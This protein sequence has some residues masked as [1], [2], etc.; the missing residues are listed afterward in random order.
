DGQT[1]TGSWQQPC[2][3]SWTWTWTWD[4]SAGISS[5]GPTDTTAAETAAQ[6]GGAATEIGAITQSNSAASVAD[7]SVERS[8]AQ[9]FDQSQIA[10][11]ATGAENQSITAEQTL[12]SSQD[13]LASAEADQTDAWNLVS[14]RGAA[15]GAVSQ[16]NRVS[17]EAL[18]DVTAT[19]SQG[20]V[21][22]QTSTTATVQ[23]ASTTQWLGNT[24]SAVAA[25]EA[26]Q[27]DG[28]N[29]DIVS[30]AAPN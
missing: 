6:P 22:H 21:Q 25:A 4:W 9:G 1:W 8:A 3:C 20:N 29:F 19:I 2:D 27:T 13:A 26:T 16:L 10:A 18:A 5:F 11:D 14:V 15:T 12:L 30:A 17:A 24:Q 28:R 23:S 7:A